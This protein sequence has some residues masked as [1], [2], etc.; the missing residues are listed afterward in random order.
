[1]TSLSSNSAQRNAQTCLDEKTLLYH[2]LYS[3][4][5][6]RVDDDV[7]PPAYMEYCTSTK[8]CLLLS[9]IAASYKKISIGNWEGERHQRKCR[10]CTPHIMGNVTAMEMGS[11]YD[12]APCSSTK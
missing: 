6:F 7:Q 11:D 9:L 10:T 3:S 12:S 5:K 4:S 1:M 2:K 8:Y